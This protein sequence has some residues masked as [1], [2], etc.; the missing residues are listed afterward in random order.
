MV[1]ASLG[2]VQG[3]LTL[4]NYC[5]ARVLTKGIPSINK[6][7]DIMELICLQVL[8]TQGTDQERNHTSL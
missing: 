6:Q 3:S 1:S 7:G 4:R 5:C 2:R 8:H